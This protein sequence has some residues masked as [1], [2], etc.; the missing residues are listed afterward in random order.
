M[1]GRIAVVAVSIAD[2][3]PVMVRV[4]ADREETVVEVG[5]NARSGRPRDDVEG[6]LLAQRARHGERE[7]RDVPGT[8]HR[9]QT[10]VL[11]DLL[12]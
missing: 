9:R 10:A 12:P 1:N 4:G 11:V 2:R 5:G 3:V 6:R 8:S 7:G